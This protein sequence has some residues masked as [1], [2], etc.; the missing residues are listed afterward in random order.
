MHYEFC[1]LCWHHHWIEEPFGCVLCEDCADDVE[2]NSPYPENWDELRRAAYA[3][4]GYKCVNCGLG[5]VVLHAHH[6]VPL[7]G[8][9]SNLLSNLATLCK[10]CHAKIHPHMISV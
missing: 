3:R 5:N 9:G 7:L 4:D 6:I 2:T 1:S 10:D 8:G